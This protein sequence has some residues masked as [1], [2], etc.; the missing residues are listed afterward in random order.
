MKTIRWNIPWSCLF[1]WEAY[2]VNTADS[3]APTKCF[4]GFVSCVTTLT[5][6]S[7]GFVNGEI[8]FVDFSASVLNLRSFLFSSIKSLAFSLSN[9]FSFK[10]FSFCSF[11]CLH[12]SSKSSIL[13]FFRSRALW[14]AIRFFNFRLIIF[15]SGVRWVSRW[16][17]LFWPIL[18]SLFEPIVSVSDKSLSDSVPMLPFELS[19]LGIK[20]IL[21]LS[22]KLTILNWLIF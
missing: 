2:L 14:A 17:F 22:F 5:S 1:G 19:L 10:S 16:R 4:S 7:D 3:S 13:T 15:S 11:N 20:S 21:L 12:V 6:S 9:W 18:F 8:G